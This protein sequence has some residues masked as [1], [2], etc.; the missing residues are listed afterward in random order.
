MANFLGGVYDFAGGGSGFPS[1]GSFSIGGVIFH[2]R[3]HFPL[4]GGSRVIV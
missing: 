3:G 4:G 1:E 2:R